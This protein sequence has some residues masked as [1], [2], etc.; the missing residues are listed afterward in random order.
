MYKTISGPQAKNAS[1]YILEVRLTA[2]LIFG[3]FYILTTTFRFQN[4]GS[5]YNLYFL[6]YRHVISNKPIFFNNMTYA[7]H[8]KIDN[9]LICY[10]C[11][12]KYPFT[13]PSFGAA[14]FCREIVDIIMFIRKS[15]ETLSNVGC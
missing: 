14:A 1:H 7:E 11:S 3:G 9:R 12:K 15:P 4:V 13:N 6:I 2:S 5:Q 8:V 10:C